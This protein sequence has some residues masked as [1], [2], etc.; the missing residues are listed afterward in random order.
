MSYTVHILAIALVA[1]LLTI[2][3]STPMNA[4]EP[5]VSLDQM[6]P[7][8]ACLFICNICFPEPEDTTHLLDCSN[9]VCGPVM[10][11]LCAMEKF[12][13]L[14]HHCRHYGDVESMWTS[15]SIH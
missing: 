6:E 3:T 12:I 1:T 15:H 4:V 10:A 5:V 8:H 2:V 13:W 14:G 7:D 9:R 11:G